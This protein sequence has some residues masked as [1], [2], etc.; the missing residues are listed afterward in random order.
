MGRLQKKIRVPDS[1]PSRQF[2]PHFSQRDQGVLAGVLIDSFAGH[3]ARLQILLDGPCLSDGG[4]HL[5]EQGLA[6]FAEGN[7][8]AKPGSSSGGV[9]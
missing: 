3:Y 4:L 9:P 2:R 1:Y 8:W 7:H 5:R 6:V